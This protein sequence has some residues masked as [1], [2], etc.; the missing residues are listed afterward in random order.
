MRVFLDQGSQTS[1]ITEKAAQ[2]LK[3][4]RKK[5]NGYISGIGNN[6]SNCKGTIS[7]KCTSLINDFSFETDVFIMK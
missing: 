3:L 6:E 2:L 5:C 1:I 7:I 4:P